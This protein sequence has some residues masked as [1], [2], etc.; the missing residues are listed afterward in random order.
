MA[1]ELTVLSLLKYRARYDKLAR[2]VPAHVLNH[3]TQVILKDYDAYYKEFP[4]VDRIEHDPFFF[5]FK[6]VR[7][8][9][10]KPEDVAIYN[11]LLRK[12]Q[13]D[14]SP[15][16]EAGLMDR[17]VQLSAATK[18]QSLIELFMDGG[19]VHFP[20][21]L[22]KINDQM[23]ADIV[24]KVKT[25]EVKTAIED[26][27]K[28][29]E[30]DTGLHWRLDCLNRSIR[31]LRGGDFGII[32]GRPDKGK[33]SFLTSE[34]TFMAQQVE[35]LY[36]N[37]GR[38]IIW[39]NNEGPG[40]RIKYRCYQSA[41]NATTQDMVKLNAE[42][43]LHADYAAA[44]GGRADIIRVFDIHEWWNYE[45][46]ELLTG[47]KP[48]LVVID[49]VDNLRFGGDVGNN[50]QRTDQLLEAMYQWARTKAVKL[51]VPVLAT[52]QISADGDGMSYPT[53]S[54]LKDSKTGKQG[55]AEFIITLGALNE[56]TM[57]NSRFIGMTKNKLHKEG[58]PK[59]P[60]CEVVFDGL[61]G[62][63]SMPL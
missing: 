1:V 45:V 18:V 57:Q 29:D 3:Q 40:K 30:N 15:D 52:S 32:A 20:S 2:A 60:H 13:E 27:L 55:A 44:L 33:T 10:L 49:M 39:L 62:R 17:L 58:G 36:P 11:G 61:R 51:D 48:A 38:H 25:V 34:L 59:D 14:V 12:V 53:L 31:P 8:P 56:L 5:W 21:E 16:L 50:G 6:T 46:D 7:H 41:L 63:Y 37:E 28:E 24:R 42:G 23:D 54:M 19:E 47:L 9:K 22:K 26:M 43:K 4:D 35:L